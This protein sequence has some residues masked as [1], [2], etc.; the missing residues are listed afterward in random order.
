MVLSLRVGLGASGGVPLID[1]LKKCKQMLMRRDWRSLAMT[2]NE[3]VSI[4]SASLQ[5][6]SDGFSS[7]VT[8]PIGSC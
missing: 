1:M 8:P 3:P 7:V 2:P 4:E 6:Q 5:E